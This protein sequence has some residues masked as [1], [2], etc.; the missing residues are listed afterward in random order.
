MKKLWKILVG[1]LVVLAIVA[2][3]L[4][5]SLDKVVL[6]ATNAAGPQLLGVP[7]SLAKADISL[8]RGKAALGGLHVGN[9]EGFK[10]DGLLDLGSVAVRLDNKSLLSDTI[11]IKEITID[12]LVV[13]YEQG[14]RGSNLG[15]LIESLSGEEKEAEEKPEAEEKAGEEKPAK[16][17]IIEKLSITGSRLNFSLTGAAAL[18][19][20]GAVPIPLPPITLTDL[21][22]DKDGATLLETIQSVLQAIA[23]AAGSAIG[24]AGHLLGDGVQAIGGAALDT[25]KAVGG[26]AVDAGK[27]VGGVA[28]DAGKAIGGAAVDAGKAVGDTLKHLNPLKK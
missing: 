5:L 1:I 26:A 7:V 23:G 11:V 24:G 15:A 19:G 6:K 3:V 25:G 21:G 20:G 2:V 18:T 28:A 16:K 10:T 12:G 8:F 4:E 14:L 17:V 13:T 27:A 9:P 22:K